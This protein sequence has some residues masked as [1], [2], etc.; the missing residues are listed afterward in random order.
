[1]CRSRRAKKLVP[2]IHGNSSFDEEV[3]NVGNELLRK[4]GS[5]LVTY[6]G[7]SV[8]NHIK[9][10]AI[11][12]ALGNVSNTVELNDTE[13]TKHESDSEFVDFLGHCKAGKYSHAFFVGTNPYY[14]FYNLSLLEGAL[15]KVPTKVSLSTSPDETSKQCLYVSPDRH[16][17]EKWNDYEISKGVFSF[18]QPVIKSLFN[19]RPLEDSFL[20]WSEDKKSFLDVMK[21]TWRK[22]LNKS[23]MDFDVKWNK[24]I[25]DGILVRRVNRGPELRFQTQGKSVNEKAPKINAGVVLKTYQKI[26]LHKGK[27]ANNPWLQELPDPITKATWDNYLQ[28]S[29]KYADKNGLKLGD[30]VEIVVGG[31][32][33]RIPILV[34][35]GTN[36]N[37]VGL[38]LGYGRTV[39][40]RAGKDVGVNAFGF[41]RYQGQSFSS[42]LEL[43]SL[44][45]LNQSYKIAQTQTHHS[46][47]GR[48]IVKETVL[49]SYVKDPASGNSHEVHLYSMWKGHKKKG[50]QWAMAIDLNKCTGCSGCVVSCNAENNVPVV[51]KEEVYNRREMHWI[52]LDRYYKGEDQNPQVVHQPMTCMH[53][54]NAPCETVCP[55]LATVQS[56]DG[57]NQQVYNRCVGTRY[58]AN[59]CPYKVRRFNWFEYARDD[60]LENMVLNPDVTV[61]SRG[62]M[63]KCTMCIQRIQEKR[64]L[65]KKEGR[66]IKDGEIQLACQQ[67]CPGDAIVFGDLNDPNSE[68]S[69]KIKDPRYYRAIEELGIE[70]RVGYMTKVRN[71]QK[72]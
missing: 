31:N 47:E 13:Y 40:G 56:S 59:N 55:V 63:E 3:I 49:G 45:K 68:I 8:E 26:G 52:R 9:V 44:V 25:H 60:K 30:L 36:D 46:L 35:P 65:A 10:N 15:G 42:G 23:G 53:C 50:N 12:E 41:T 18:A 20:I 72:R 57:L 71:D 67:S 6:G 37:T 51:G 19:N 21:E 32:K 22:I 38:A 62:V 24:M 27:F 70:P 7:H 48:D 29:P 4:K 1:M 61:R 17:L 64:I 14:D 43:E 16:Y 69:K 33:L 5:G 11:N 34:Q 39:C 54:D 2:V 58:C 66:E 28:V